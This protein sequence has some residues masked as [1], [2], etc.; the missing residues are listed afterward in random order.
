M[1]RHFE[2]GLFTF[3]WFAIVCCLLFAFAVNVVLFYCGGGSG[4]FK[5]IATFALFRCCFVG[6]FD[7]F[8]DL[9]FVV[10]FA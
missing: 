7:L 8:I 4:L 1:L 3:D 2:V 9:R 5:G 10:V 6:C